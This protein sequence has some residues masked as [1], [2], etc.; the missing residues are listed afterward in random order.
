MQPAVALDIFSLQ[1]DFSLPAEMVEGNPYF[2]NPVYPGM[3]TGL[4]IRFGDTLTHK[5]R[6]QDGKLFINEKEVLLN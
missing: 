1:S 2:L 6:T 5:A 3:Q 4:F